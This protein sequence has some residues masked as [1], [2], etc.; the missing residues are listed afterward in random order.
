VLA[1]GRLQVLEGERVD[2]VN[3]HGTGCTLSAATA[4][5][6]ACGDSPLDAVTAAKRHV[7][8]ALRGAT[9]WHLGA[10]HGPLDHFGWGGG[11]RSR[12]GS[13]PPATTPTAVP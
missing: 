1:E 5:R 11:S 3:D 8:E 7:T 2:T 4:A 9:A 6:L 10:G 13:S 12:P